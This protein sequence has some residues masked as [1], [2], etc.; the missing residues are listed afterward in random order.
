MVHSGVCCFVRARVDIRIF[1]G[2][3]AVRIRRGYLGVDRGAEVVEDGA[4][5]RGGSKTSRLSVPLVF[6]LFVCVATASQ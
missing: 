3:L 4:G 6:V 2:S 1:A 5:N